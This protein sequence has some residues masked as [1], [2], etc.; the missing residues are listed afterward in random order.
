MDKEQRERMANQAFVQADEGQA[1]IEYEVQVSGQRVEIHQSYDAEWDNEGGT[2]PD[3][4]HE[5]WIMSLDSLKKLIAS[6]QWCIEKSEAFEKSHPQPQAAT[7]TDLY[8][9]SWEQENH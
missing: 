2:G 1:D 7:S 9:Q 6:A 5:V 8:V 3:E 4:Q